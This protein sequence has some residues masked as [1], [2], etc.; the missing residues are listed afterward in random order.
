VG[1]RGGLN[2]GRGKSGTKRLWPRNKAPLFSTGLT[3][4][5][6]RDCQGLCKGGSQSKLHIRVYPSHFQ[7]GRTDMSQ[8]LVCNVQSTAGG[9]G[10]RLSRNP[11][12][13]PPQKS[14]NIWLQNEETAGLLTPSPGTRKCPYEGS[15]AGGNATDLILAKK[16]ELVDSPRAKGKGD[17]KGN[18]KGKNVVT[19]AR[20][21]S[22]ALPI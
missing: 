2:D 19:T 22:F 6:S 9:V 8:H 1:E 16:Q 7:D 10:K 14:P 18:F 17:K 13:R 20:E 21:K 4:D 12:K 15:E 5:R 11:G 3:E